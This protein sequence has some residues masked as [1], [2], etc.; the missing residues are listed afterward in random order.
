MLCGVRNY[1]FIF[2]TSLN[3]TYKTIQFIPQLR[4][5]FRRS[6]LAV[7]EVVNNLNR[8]Q[9]LHK[10]CEIIKLERPNIL[11][12]SNATSAL[13]NSNNLCTICQELKN[14][15]HILRFSLTMNI[16]PAILSE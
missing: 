5:N 7:K 2:T 11:F 16:N 8:N 13:I 3:Q 15:S 4:F 10:L 1:L 14:N 12:C 6:T 9:S